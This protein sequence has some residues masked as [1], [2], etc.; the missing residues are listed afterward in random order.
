M[1]VGNELAVGDEFVRKLGRRRSMGK[2]TLDRTGK[3]ER[4][5]L[6]EKGW[7]EKEI[8]TFEGNAARLDGNPS[9]FSFRKMSPEVSLA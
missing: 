7:L 3:H 4:I 9:F 2:G 5:L 1:V 8:E 6:K